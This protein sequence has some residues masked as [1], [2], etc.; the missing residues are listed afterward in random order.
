MDWQSYATQVTK[1]AQLPKRQGQVVLAGPACYVVCN[2]AGA[3]FQSAGLVPA[4][5][6][7]DG[8]FSLAMA[9]VFDCTAQNADANEV[10]SQVPVLSDPLSYCSSLSNNGFVGKRDVVMTA[11]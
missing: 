2:Q 3:V 7:Q 6:A 1:R 9:A 11:A 5:C 10:T 4:L 8:E